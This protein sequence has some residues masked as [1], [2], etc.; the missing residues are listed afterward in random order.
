M[1][2]KKYIIYIN[3]HIGYIR[4]HQSKE[5]AHVSIAEHAYLDEV[6]DEYICMIYVLTMHI[7]A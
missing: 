1:Y 2:L 4:T 7:D 6:I 5:H 3:T